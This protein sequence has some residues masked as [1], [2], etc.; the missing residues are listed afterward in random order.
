MWTDNY[1]GLP[2]LPDGRTRDGLDCWGIVRLAYQEQRGIELPSYSGIYTMDTAEKLREVAEMMERESIKWTQ[3]DTPQDFDVVRLRI[4]GKLAFHV[5]LVVG[6][7]FL[8]VMSGIQST[9][10]RLN[11]P[12][13]AQKITGYYRYAGN[14]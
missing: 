1:I 14:N 9:V 10:E 12:V 11:S 2:F 8:H 5:G 7:D 4:V 6:K 13:W 3:V